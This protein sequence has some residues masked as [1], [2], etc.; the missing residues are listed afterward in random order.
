MLMKRN[1]STSQEKERYRGE[2]EKEKR[3]REREKIGAPKKT[4][5]REKL[6]FD[7]S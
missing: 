6:H 1:E 2:R 4:L 5:E 3:M 7:R